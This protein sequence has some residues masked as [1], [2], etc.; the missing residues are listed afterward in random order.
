MISV[1]ELMG[2]PDFTQPY[3]ILRSTGNWLTGVWTPIITSVQN[4]G[5]IEVSS[6][7]DVEMTPEGDVIR[8]FMVF[9][10][11]VA[12]YTTH[13]GKQDGSSD[14]LIWRSNQFRVM[15]VA[16]WVDYGYFRAVATRL[17]SA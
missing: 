4:Y 3:T 9:W 11:P 12:I 13:E 1:A 5:V 16:K 14:I 8:G 17:L 7:K 15:S 6:P 10:S 2:D